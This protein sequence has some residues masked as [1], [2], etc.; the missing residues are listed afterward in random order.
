VSVRFLADE[1]IDVD[2]VQGLHS[3]ESA[4]DVLD[5][6][7]A[8]M[9]GTKDLA[10]LEIAAEQG[11]ILITYDRNT[12]TQYFYE[13]SQRGNR[14]QACSSSPKG[15]AV[16]AARSNGCY[17]SGVRLNQRSGAIGSS[18]CL[19]AKINRWTG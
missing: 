19:A 4:I 10:L 2:I 12:M 5:V 3:R 15:Q 6:K 8:G 9:R 16:S 18:M 17:L 7:S 14:P 1:N 13:R 11:R